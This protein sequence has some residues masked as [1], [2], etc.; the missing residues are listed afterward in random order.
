M[1]GRLRN[2][3]LC[4]NFKFLLSRVWPVVLCLVTVS[5]LQETSTNQRS[6]IDPAISTDDTTDI[7][8][9]IPAETPFSF[10]SNFLQ[11]GS[12]V[13]TTTFN[14]PVTY[15]KILYLRGNNINQFLS[16]RANRL[17]EQ[18][19][20]SFFPNATPAKIL[21]MAAIPDFFHNFSTN[22]RE[23]FYR[24]TIIDGPINQSICQTPDLLT[25]LDNDPQLQGIA[26][27]NSLIN[28]CPTCNVAVVGRPLEI[29]ATNG[30]PINAINIGHLSL[31]LTGSIPIDVSVQSCSGSSECQARGLDCCLNGQCVKDKQ[32]RSGIDQTSAEFL[33]SV[34][35]IESFPAS[36]F[37][38]PQFYY[39]CS[40]TPPDGDTTI[41][42]P[43]LED[44]LAQELARKR[45][46]NL[47]DLFNCTTSGVDE[48][49]I[50]TTTIDD[51]TRAD[52]PFQ[53]GRDDRHFRDNYSGQDVNNLFET[54]V[55]EIVHAGSVLFKNGQ[56]ITG[57]PADFSIGPGN[58][59]LSDATTVTINRIPP[60]SANSN[61]LK[62]RYQIDGSCRKFSATI[63]QCTK[64]YVQGQNPATNEPGRPSDHFPTSDEFKLPIHTDTS[65]SLVVNVDGIFSSQILQWNLVLGATPVVKFIA[66]NIPVD[67]Q[68][69]TIDYFASLTQNPFII[70]SKQAAL[71]QINQMC[72]C[73][74][75]DCSLKEVKKVISGVEQVVDFSCVYPPPPLGKSHLYNKLSF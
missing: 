19:V 35:N 21:L 47:T 20:M 16:L 27:E 49:S 5:C 67:G 59:N 61:E 62:I 26:V 11:D 38:Y 42:D 56:T 74:T 64:H 10:A 54:S 18:C 69:I 7:P 3:N 15:N 34:Q 65:R 39:I 53:T 52:T 31:Q 4:Q 22:Q 33:Q 9:A 46:E 72:Q 75:Q 41:P 68:K 70:E 1:G 48:L 51:I 32:I 13:I 23:Y 60:A 63:A 6:S 30:S 14:I 55:V 43:S 71:D 25:A 44:V 73:G 24:L 66:G 36:I 17:I 58:D 40:S 2:L 45:L 28:V 57:N 29:F 8:D 12:N 50:C 37:N